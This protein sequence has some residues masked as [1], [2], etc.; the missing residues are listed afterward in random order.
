MTDG[1]RMTTDRFF[2][3]VDGRLENLQSMLEYVNNNRTTESELWNW[4]ESHTAAESDSTIEKYLGFQQSIELLVVQSDRYVTTSRG[5]EFAETG[6]PAVIA[7]ALLENVKGFETILQAI[8]SGY[9]TREEI[10]TQLRDQ[11][12]GYSLPLSIVGRQLEWLRAIDAIEL[13]DE[14]FQLKPLG[15]RLAAE[16]EADRWITPQLSQ[17]SETDSKSA[18]DRSHDLQTLREEAMSAATESASQSTTTREVTEYDRSDEIRD[19]VIARANGCCEGCREPAPFR[20]RSGDP[21]LHSHHV[22]ELADGGPDSP[23]HVIALCPNCDY[24]VH[25]GAD[26]EAYNRELENR[27]AVIEET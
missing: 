21:Y 19:Y 24:R 25:H 4:L 27:L 23:E 13:R 5:A 10:Q 9:R 18:Q 7:Q 16:F 8:E 3:G 14:Q 11:Y 12:P 2:G 15:Q 26:G 6:D 20:N 22:H 1:R 17:S